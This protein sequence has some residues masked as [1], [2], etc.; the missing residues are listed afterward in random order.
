[1]KKRIFALCIAVML[2]ALS[3]NVLAQS[4]YLRIQDFAGLLD[5]SEYELIYS[6]IIRIIGYIKNPE[7][8][9][10]SILIKNEIFSLY[11]TEV[12]FSS[13]VTFNPLVS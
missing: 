10:Q 2:I 12:E 9:Y 3:F 6:S 13:R 4:E 7:H 8:T 5:E 1:M 11:E